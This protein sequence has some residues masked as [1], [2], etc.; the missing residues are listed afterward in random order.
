MNWMVLLGVSTGM[1][2]MTATAVLCWYAW[3]GLLPQHGWT[4]WA[5]NL[6][7]VIVFTLMALGEYFGDTRPTTPSRTMLPLV[8]ARLFFGALAGTLA[9]RSILEPTAGGVVFGIAGA[10][11]GTYGGHWVRVNTARKVGRDLP[12]ALT[13]SALALAFALFAAHAL[14]VDGA[15]QGLFPR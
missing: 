6:I 7:S 12:V 4:F 9:A 15:K 1:R 13:E 5:G 10:L 11:I 2:T 14:H 8:L 3:L